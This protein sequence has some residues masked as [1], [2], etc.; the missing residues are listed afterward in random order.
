MLALLGALAAIGLVTA[1]CSSDD[2]SASGDGSAVEVSVTQEPDPEMVLG[3]TLVV[4]TDR[5]ARV[6]VA[7][8][9]DAHAV[10]LPVTAEKSTS[11]TIA[12]VGLRPEGDYAIT[13]DA[14]GD[15]GQVLGTATTEFR[16]GALP[17]FVPDLDQRVSEPDARADGVTFVEIGPVDRAGYEDGEDPLAVQHVVALDDEGE[18]VWYSAPQGAIGDVKLTDRGTILSVDF[19]FAVR[20]TDLMG[21]VLHYW[22]AQGQPM[23]WTDLEAVADADGEP[24]IERPDP[25]LVTAD[26]VDIRSFHH[27]AFPMPD[28][29]IL[30]LATTLHELTPG[31]RAEL[32]PGDG[33]DFWAISDVAVE[34]TPAGEVLRTW[35]LW[36]V[37]DLM[38]TPG[39][40]MCTTY[41]QIATQIE[42]DWGHGNA[43][44]YD[45]ERDAVIVSTRH[46]SQIV[47]MAHGEEDGAQD[48]LLWTIGT[49]G[50]IPLD[51][52]VPRYQHAVEVEDDGSILFYDNG[53][54]REGT[55]PGTDNPPY[56]RAALFAVD[57]SSDD[58]S[59]WS[60]TQTWEHRADES[61]GT[62]VFASFVGDADRL[63][64]GNVLIDHGGIPHPNPTDDHNRCMIIEVV[65][66]GSDSGGE[67]VWDLRIGTAERPVL[68]YRAHHYPSLYTG[69]QWEGD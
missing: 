19:P 32:C 66:D 58:P 27:E 42:R 35:D 16:S 45:A 60:A 46:T 49:D 3:T 12:L 37:I 54:G 40:E 7:A 8:E 1:G 43:V 28:G 65:P 21:N 44:V 30:A 22:G 4:Q 63:E 48:Q 24:A 38:E 14:V 15:D 5:D 10:E 13:V 9:A 64:N 68:C 34:F 67:I 55:A 41:G 18:V 33:E 36:D 53:N 26:W 47:A 6:A 11:H 61:P 51:G 2:A 17:E 23:P 39:E 56:S 29:N 25:T 69:P 57:D 50:T 59:D 52:D 20:E 62:P 31:Q